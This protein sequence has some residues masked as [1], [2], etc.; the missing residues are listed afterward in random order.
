MESSS[1]SAYLPTCPMTRT[2]LARSPCPIALPN[3]IR[4]YLAKYC[5]VKFLSTLGHVDVPKLLVARGKIPVPRPEG[6]A[7]SVSGERSQLAT[8][9]RH[10]CLTCC[11]AAECAELATRRRHMYRLTCCVAAEFA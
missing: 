2:P 3:T 6:S 5:F 9:C 1:G 10:M 11:V 4:P 7:H 8:I